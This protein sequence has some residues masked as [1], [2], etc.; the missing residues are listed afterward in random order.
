MKEIYVFTRPNVLY[1]NTDLVFSQRE[2]DKKQINKTKKVLWCRSIVAAIY[3][4][5]RFS[6]SFGLKAPK[7]W[8]TC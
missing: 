3:D 8:D 1:L 7:R 4:N 5:L 2:M 6:S